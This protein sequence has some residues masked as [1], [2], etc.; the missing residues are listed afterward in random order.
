VRPGLTTTEILRHRLAGQMLLG[1]GAAIATD[2]VR[3][4]GA[5]QAQE[6]G[7]T[8][9]SVAMRTRGSAEGTTGILDRDVEQEVNDG[10]ILRTHILRPTWHFVAV[11]DIRWMLALS[12]PRVHQANAFPYR[13]LEMDAAVFRKSHKVLTKALD[14]GKQLT[15]DELGVLLDRAGVDIRPNRLA[16]LLMQAELD[17]VIVSG[18]RRGKLHT[19]MLF[20]ERVPPFPAIDRDEALE[21]L[22][23]RYFPTRG[24][25]SAHDFAWWSGL[26][27]KD[28]RRAIDI[29]SDELERVSI[30][31]RDHWMARAS[32]PPAG[33]RRRARSTAEDPVITHLLPVYDEFFIG[34]KNR[35][36]IGN[37]LTEAT[38]AT[39]GAGIAPQFAFVNGELVARWKRTVS[40]KRV[41]VEIEPLTRITE[42]EK[43][44]ISAEA[45]KF[46]AFLELPFE[47]KHGQIAR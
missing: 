21:R 12:A 1:A 27:L 7:P 34:L 46:A 30:D 6:Y 8:K 47:L 39:L 18:A 32:A 10:R 20:D 25:A 23:L 28:V 16:N 38:R 41:R 3:A 24:P 9:W 19:Y 29:A 37:R 45:V 2:V 5:V 26:T 14:G 40:E 44:G 43:K 22:A 17:G 11:D 35:S 31:D 33:A 4:L 13:R 36:A 42:A 15:R